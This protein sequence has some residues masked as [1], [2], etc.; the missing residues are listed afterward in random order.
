M[1]ACGGICS[2]DSDRVLLRWSDSPNS[3]FREEI[4]QILTSG[5]SEAV[6]CSSLK[7]REETRVSL[8]GN[9]YSEFGTVR[10]CRPEG[11]KFVVTIRIKPEASTLGYRV[12]PGVFAINDFLTEEDELR[13]LEELD[14]EL[15]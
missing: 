12:D 6:V 2:D 4:V 10:S 1:S 15:Q 11:G 5:F 13:I 14:Q 7:I 3:T 8:I 9:F